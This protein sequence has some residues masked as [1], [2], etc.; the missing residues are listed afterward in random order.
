E[1]DD[2]SKKSHL[3]LA[4]RGA[5]PPLAETQSRLRDALVAGDFTRL[6]GL[7]IGGGDAAPRFA[8]HRRHYQSSLIEALLVKFPAT[9]WLVGTPALEQAARDFV[10]A[11]PPRAPCIAEY[12]D[13]FPRFIAERSDAERTDYV[14]AFAELEWHLGQVSIAIDAPAVT[15][16]QLSHHETDV[17]LGSAL[18]LQPGLRYLAAAW[19]VDDLMR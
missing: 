1:R 8:I 16:D 15:V 7:L 12:A 11:H 6:E 14:R 13:A 4:A 5:M 2:D 17:L 18:T 19:P 10:C 9:A 3:A